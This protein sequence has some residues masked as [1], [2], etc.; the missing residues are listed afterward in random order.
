MMPCEI[1]D[2]NG[3]PL[4]EGDLSLFYFHDLPRKDDILWLNIFDE[5]VDC[6][7]HVRCEVVY[8]AQWATNASCDPE[9]NKGCIFVRIIDQDDEIKE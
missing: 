7:R 4:V 8:S 6:F 1:Y 2:G 5:G 9:I 3:K